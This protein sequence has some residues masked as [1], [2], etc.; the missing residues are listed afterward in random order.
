MFRKITNNLIDWKNNKNRKPLLII[1]ARQTGKTYIIKEF[2]T[3]YYD[4][5]LEVNFEKDANL[6]NLFKGNIDSKNLIVKLENYY[7]K[8]IYPEKTLIF[9]DEIQCCEQALT[10]LK[11]F[12]EDANM[13]HIIAAGSLLG[14]ILN[15]KNVSFPVGKV[16][17][18]KMYPM[19][20]EEFLI[21]LNQQILIETIQNC[22][23]NNEK[24]EET[25]HNKALAL[26][27]SYLVVG[28]MP[29]AVQEY[30]DSGSFIST[31][32]IVERI[33]SNYLNDLPKYT[34]L[35]ESV[36]NKACYETIVSQL[37]KENKNF[38]YS[39][40]MVGKNSQYFGSSIDWLNFA[41]ITLKSKMIDIPRKPLA[42]H[43]NNFLF[44]L[45][46]SDVGLFRYSANLS[47]S[48]I[49]DISYRDD[50]T[51]IIAENYVACE[52][53]SNNIPLF[54]WTG[55]RNSEIEF[56]IENNTSV[57]PVEVKAGKRVTSKSLD[58][59]K[60]MYTVD[61]V[62]RISGKNFGFENSIKSVPLYSVFC[63]AKE[64]TNEKYKNI[65]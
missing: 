29:E 20:F 51:G 27:R 30:V 61:Y 8:R 9:F 11:Y 15:R 52:L 25:L 37:F 53:V 33:Y 59:Y 19:D 16:N 36:K 56:L 32:Q 47:I 48:S 54:Y 49:L 63:L 28:G 1:G 22:Y 7:G 6:K 55:K 42:Y 44:R 31:I 21:A 3:N 39:E 41:G 43:S 34:S 24:M 35:S 46:L 23:N 2:A 26:Y 58:V 10:S 18:M 60:E 17:E 14:V 64:I 65:K 40:V 13:Y 38:K 57:I 45:Y 50:L 12:N 4:Y 62:Y 5:I